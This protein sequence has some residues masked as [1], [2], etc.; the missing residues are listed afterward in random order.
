MTGILSPV[1]NVICSVADRCQVK[2]SLYHSTNS[3]VVR[4]AIRS[5]PEAAFQR[6]CGPVAGKR[7]FHLSARHSQ[8]NVD[9]SN[10]SHHYLLSR[11]HSFSV[12]TAA[13]RAVPARDSPLFTVSPFPVMPSSRSV[14]S[15]LAVCSAL[16]AAAASLLYSPRGRRLFSTSSRTGPVLPEREGFP[17]EDRSGP[18][19]KG[20]PERKPPPGTH[21]GAA[22]KIRR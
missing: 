5:D 15:I 2:V 20:A 3:F 16:P 14:L 17:A 22:A 7:T 1:W 13:R 12:A 19:S 4:W 11:Y 6:W 9:S 18:S 10:R 21:L 8:L